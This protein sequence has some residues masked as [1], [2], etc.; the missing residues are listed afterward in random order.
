MKRSD[1]GTKVTFFTV[2]RYQGGGVAGEP[3]FPAM[4]QFKQ[5]VEQ[6]CQECAEFKEYENTIAPPLSLPPAKKE[7]VLTEIDRQMEQIV[8][9]VNLINKNGW[10]IKGTQG[11]SSVYR[12]ISGNHCTDEKLMNNTIRRLE[13]KFSDLQFSLGTG[14]DYDGCPCCMYDT[15]EIKVLFPEDNTPEAV[16]KWSDDFVASIK[17]VGDSLDK[18][19]QHRIQKYT[20]ERQAKV[21]FLKQKRDLLRD[22]ITRYKEEHNLQKKE[23]MQE[24]GGQMHKV[25]TLDEFDSLMLK[26]ACQFP[27][28][29]PAYI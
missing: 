2:K 16:K 27:F 29:N 18:E 4:D 8:T 23:E 7:K 21:D 22:D 13:Q 10:G 19:K 3:W 9:F 5:R 15:T 17:A 28:D 14:S 11:G 1:R 25:I 26:L 20:P 24:W 6:L 12:I